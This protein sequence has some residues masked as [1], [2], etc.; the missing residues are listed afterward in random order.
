MTAASRLMPS[1]VAPGVRSARY[2]PGSDADRC[3]ALLRA[4]ANEPNRRARFTCAIAIAGAKLPDVLPA[5]LAT[6]DGCVVAVG[7]FEGMLSSAPKGSSGFG[8]DPIFQLSDGR[9][10]GELSAAEKHD[11]TPWRSPSI[12]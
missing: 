10:V 4:M 6:V 1:A 8:Y 3:S 5:G 2:A 12:Y 11:L 9:T 7:H